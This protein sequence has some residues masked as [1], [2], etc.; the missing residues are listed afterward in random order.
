MPNQPVVDSRRGRP[1]GDKRERTRAALIKAASE[2][3]GEKG[4]DCTSLEEVA[5]RAGMTRGAIYGNFKHREDL[6]LAVVRANWKPV[7][8]P[9][10]PGMTFHEYMKT[11]GKALAETASVRRAQGVGALSFMLYALT[12]EEMRSR[13]RQFNAELY[14][15]G[16]QRLRQSFP[17]RDLPMPPE[18]MVRVIHALTEGLTVLRILT[19]ELITDDVVMNAFDALAV[20]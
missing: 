5:A 12:H 13:V 10:S 15:L 17:K 8:P 4:W 16:A 6:F 11:L 2:V 1:K 9:L 7:M 18:H 19:P 14:A 3:I 20:N